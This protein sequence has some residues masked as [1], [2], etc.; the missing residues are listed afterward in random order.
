MGETESSLFKTRAL[1][2]LR[3]YQHTKWVSG[4]ALAISEV[5]AAIKYLGGSSRKTT[6]QTTVS[7][8]IEI[9]A[10]LSGAECWFR[11]ICHLIYLEIQTGE[12]MPSQQPAKN[13]AVIL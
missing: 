6:P 11:A 13:R 12:E 7:S 4:K 8:E 3:G 9:P 1:L 5:N 10:Q 2:S